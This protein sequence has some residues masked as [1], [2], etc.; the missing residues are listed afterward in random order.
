MRRSSSRDLSLHDFV[1]AIL[2]FQKLL[3]A[4]NAK[5]AALEERVNTMCEKSPPSEKHLE[6]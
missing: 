5:L 4:S 1:A 6:G 3:V 2:E